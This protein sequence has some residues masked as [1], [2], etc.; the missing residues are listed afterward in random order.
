MRTRHLSWFLV[1]ALGIGLA[2]TD[3]AESGWVAQVRAQVGVLPSRPRRVMLV[4]PLVEAGSEDGTIGWGRGLIA[5]HAMWL[6][7]F[8]PHRLLDTWDFT[9]HWRFAQHQLLG[10]GRRVTPEKIDAICATVDAQNYVTGTLAVDDRSYKAHLTLQ[11][12][13]HRST[14]LFQNPGCCAPKYRP[15]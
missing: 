13:R 11:G 8:A 2:R 3:G 15:A 1:C 12:V 10:P 6:S 7:S 4:F 5:V 9:V 14:T